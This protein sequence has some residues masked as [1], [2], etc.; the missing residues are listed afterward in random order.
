M[1]SEPGP[2]SNQST[3]A[4]CLSACA[5]QARGPRVPSHWWQ[6]AY[7][8]R[9]KLDHHVAGNNVRA[10]D[11][12]ST[13]GVSVRMSSSSPEAVRSEFISGSPSFAP[14][15]PLPGHQECCALRRGSDLS[16]QRSPGSDRPAWYWVHHEL[17]QPCRRATPL[18]VGSDELGQ[19]FELGP[20]R[21]GHRV[22]SI[23]T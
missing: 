2:T 12:R 15:A 8:Y 9:D 17:Q 11:Q 1:V 19:R 3:L 23:T 16:A 14:G 10:L 4:Y 6:L 18:V 22:P 13:C 20:R 5:L 21:V 7:R